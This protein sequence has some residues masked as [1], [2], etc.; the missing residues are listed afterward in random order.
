MGPK[1]AFASCGLPLLGILALAVAAGARADDGDPPGRAARLGYVEGAVS[2]EPAG[3]QDWTVADRNRPLTSGDR[4]WTDQD[5]VAE[6]DLGSAVVR[7]GAMTGFAFLN[8]DDSHAQMQLSAGVIIVRVWDMAQGQ[9]YEIDTPNLALALQQPGVYRIEVDEPGG[10]TTVK[11]SEGEV[12]A[13][14]ADE[15]I[16][17]TTQ[18]VMTFAGTT[19]LSYSAATLGPPDDFDTWSDARDHQEEQSPSWQYVADDTP[20][21]VSLDD[22]GRWMDTPQYG[23]VWIPVVVNAGWVP[24][25][26]GH[27]A[28]VAPWGWT[29]VDDA[30]WGYTPFHYGRWV[31]WEGSWCWLPGPRGS[32][33]VFAPA[34][35]AWTGGPPP[36]GGIAGNV[37]W[38]PLGPREVYAPAYPVSSGY[39]QRVNRANTTVVSESYVTNVYRQQVTDIH[40]VNSTTS[41]VTTVPQS[42]FTAAQGVAK[43]AMPV[44]A[45]ALAAMTVTA[46]APA[47]APIRQSVLGSG[48]GPGAHPPPAL[49][50]RPVVAHTPPPR[51]PVSFD[52]QLAAIQANGGRPLAPGELRR[53]QPGAPTAQV[54][55]LT[56]T[57]S[58]PLTRAQPPPEP[59]LGDRARSLQNSSIPPATTTT[60]TF[61]QE[62]TPAPLSDRPPSGSPRAPGQSTMSVYHNDNPPPQIEVRPTPAPTERDSER[63]TRTPSSNAP[64]PQ[65]NRPPP[66]K[67]ESR[68]QAQKKE[69]REESGRKADEPKE[70]GE[71]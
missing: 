17:V 13:I 5:A 19:T 70:R 33:P 7:L 25:R 18:Q 9:N 31:F 57:S 66:Q 49:A 58:R 10:T 54:R 2:L 64:A 48:T 56:G 68:P 15:S 21:S 28:W 24:Y 16:P 20:G 53:L 45:G 3:T 40:Y 27:W 39:L 65:R 8:L 37:G 51:P 1:R 36:P 4:L 55:V 44:T 46:A 50:N 26:F 32:R 38:F 67:T 59:S 6:L 30:P 11:V 23:P 34:L 12:L 62:P 47:I 14:G 61:T 63:T 35:V 41:A 42:V 43:H 52:R 69:S 29:W 71:K 60:R 22:N